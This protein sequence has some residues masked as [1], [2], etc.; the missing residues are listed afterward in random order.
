[1]CKMN[2]IFGTKLVNLFRQNEHIAVAV[3]SADIELRS[4]TADRFFCTDQSFLF[5]SLDIHFQKGYL[6]AAENVV[7]AVGGDFR[8]A[9]RGKL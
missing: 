7:N 1:M 3:I 8:F 2:F 4:V 6:S 9:R 5:A